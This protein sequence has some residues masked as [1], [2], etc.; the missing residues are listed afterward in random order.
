MG[1]L[2]SYL[3]LS[4]E[5][6]FVKDESNSISNQRELIRKYIRKSPELMKMEQVELKDDGYS[7]KNMERPAMQE[8]LS[9]VKKGK[10]S[11]IIVK[12]ISRFSRDYIETGK[13][14]EQIFPFLGIR[15][16]SINDNY[17]STECTGGIAEIDVAFKGILYDFY[18]EDLSEKVKTSL[19]VRRAS[20][21]YLAPFA[22]YG[23]RKSEN[24]NHKLEVDEESAHI[25]KRIYN[26]Y[27]CGSSMYKIAQKLNEEHVITPAEYISRKG[28]HDTFNY[29]G[30][31]R[32]WTS[33]TV[34]RILRNEMYTGNYV[35]GRFK[36]AEVGAK[37]P[38]AQ[39]E[40]DWKKI[41]NHHEAII[42][43]EMFDT[44]QKK[45]A[46]NRNTSQVRESHCLKGKIICGNCGH[47]MT[48]SNAG[49]PKYECRHHY[50]NHSITGCVKSVRDEDIE[51]IVIQEL[52]AQLDAML[53]NEKVQKRQKQL[54]SEKMHEA[55]K[56]LRTMQLSQEKIEADL[57]NAY[58]SYKSGLT[59]KETYLEQRQVYEQLEDKIQETVQKQMKTVSEYEEKVLT[60]PA[61]FDII[62]SRTKVMELDR[63]IVET[64]VDRIVVQGN[65]EI[66]IGWKFMY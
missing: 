29:V 62:E 11:C 59:D 66:E 14:M 44:V 48:H 20:G 46:G 37:H 52:Q 53:D 32:T 8:L 60:M 57:Q 55:E 17:D 51:V 15:F 39:S 36:S 4:K 18:S 33:A 16:I 38:V 6:E 31:S 28:Y 3:R 64:F 35:Y 63:E 65:G 61:G 49:R 58:E 25:V 7:G 9:M 26:E 12:D 50:V 41:E 2:V 24:D 27:I 5:D 40:E 23:Y 22:P 21:K 54:Q 30:K 42:S 43:E 56:K 34:S 19:S 1:K 10:V 13:Y 47:K 45:R